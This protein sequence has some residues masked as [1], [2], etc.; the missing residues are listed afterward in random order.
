MF[1]LLT[2]AKFTIISVIFLA[3]FVANIFVFKNIPVGV[4]LLISFI[5]IT[6]PPFGR[7]AAPKEA[8]LAQFVFGFFSLLSLIA[9]IGS[10]FYYLAEFTA[11]VAITLVLLIPSLVWLIEKRA[12]RTAIPAGA[13]HNPWAEPL[14]QSQKIGAAVAVVLVLL[15]TTVSLVIKAATETAVRSPW[16]VVTPSVFITFGLAAILLTA[17]LVRGR[18]RILTLPL[19]SAAL[20]VFLSIAL[21]VFPLGYGFDSFIHQAT[22]SHIAE[23]GTITPKPF[24]YIGQYSIVLF[25]YHAFLVPID[26]AD[27]ILVPLL[28]ALLLPMAWFSAAAHLLKEKRSA[29]Q[30]LIPI[31]LIP[32]SSF[33]VTTPQ[34]LG[35]LW[36][37]ILVLLAAPRLMDRESLPIWPLALSALATLLIHP[38]AGIPAVLFLA[39]LAANPN[40]PKQKNPTLA[41]VFSWIIILFGCFALPIT[42]V[43]NNLRS[44]QGLGFDFSALSPLV[45]VHN[46]RLDLFFENRFSPIL[47]FVYLFGWNQIILLIIGAVIGMV[48]ARRT[49]LKNLRVYLAMAAILFINFLVIKSAIDFSFLID[50]ERGNYADRLVP[51]AIFCLV[52]FLIIL[53]GRTL[54]TLREKP[55][56]LQAGA[57]I[58][59]AALITSAFYLNYPRQDA[60]ETSHG[61]NVSRADVSA[62]MDIDRDAAGIEYAVLANQSA[63]AAAIREF[64][65][66]HYY[67]EQFYY[68]IPTGGTLYQLFLKMNEAP[69]KTT[70][71][72]AMDL[73]GIERIYYLVSDYWWQADR[74]RET[75][76]TNADDWWSVE[77]GKVTIF[78]YNR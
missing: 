68:P 13:K 17:L 1:R 51:L 27:K 42:F 25:L 74:L 4:I 62:T 77:N 48:W 59:L 56:V 18:E 46:L 67:G 19:V 7:A 15:A 2:N 10:G 54:T 45:L 24:Y 53:A 58:F 44:G 29:A 30:S 71:L 23:F 38:I 22:E 26:L 35:N 11:P 49:I 41:R 8:R 78:E 21:F 12:G 55:F 60:Y 32:L 52:P 61:Y 64:G 40:E 39:L 72:A 3:V 69:T 73:L 65:F 33:I 57:V 66:A 37:F 36:F 76:K 31:F 14:Q 43:V 70:A 34:G 6:A 75:A 63:A 28:A 20:F 47:D 16:E 5:A 9:I 50:Y